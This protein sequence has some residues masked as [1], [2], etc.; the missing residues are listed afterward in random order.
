[1]ISFNLGPNGRSKVTLIRQTEVAECGLAVVAMI[2]R[3]YGKQVSLSSLRRK[4]QTSSR[5]TTMRSLLATAEDMGLSSRAVKLPLESLSMLAVPAVLHWNLNHFVVLEQV[6]GRRA[7]IHNPEGTSRWMQ[8]DEVSNHF[9]GIAA[10]FSPNESFRLTKESEHLRFSQLW[11][12]VSGLRRAIAQTVVLTLVMQAFAIAAPYYMQISLDGVLPAHDLSLLSVLGAGF[13]LFALINSLATGLRAL[14]LLS[15]GSALSYGVSVNVARHLFRLPIDWFERRHVGDILSR[16]Q[17][18]TP[19]RQFLTEGAVAAVLDGFLGIVVLLLMIAYSKLLASVALL[20]FLLYGWIRLISFKALRTSQERVIISA[21]LEQS[22]M[23]ETVRGIATVRLAN[24]ENARHA[25][26]QAKLGDAINAGV[27][28]GKIKTFQSFAS[29]LLLSVENVIS[30][31]IAVSLVIRGG[32]S[33]GMAFAF[34]AYKSQ[35]LQ[36]GAS[37]IDQAVAYRM[38][39]LHLERLADVA[40]SDQDPCFSQS[41]SRIRDFRGKIELRNVSFSYSPSDPLVLDNI[42]LVINPNDHIAITGPSGGGK[43]TLVKI[44]LGLVS[45][46]SGEVIV[47]DVPIEIFGYTAFRQNVGAVLQDDHIFSGTLADNVTLYDENEES[48][49]VFDALTDAALAT[50]VSVMPMGIETLVGD[51]GSSLSGGQKQRLLLA[52]ALYRRPKFLVMDEGTS[53]LDADLERV[54]SARIAELGISRLIVAHRIETIRTASRVLRLLNGK[55]CEVDQAS[56]LNHH[57]D[58]ISD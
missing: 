14:V 31:W 34:M 33:I 40:L 26:W 23:I 54:V 39:S 46:T 11:R 57:Y 49:S 25:F 16:F 37:L 38:L 30:V 53:H 41:Q 32:F 55:L 20:T 15:T 22:S 7:L 24:R 48:G 56:T 13:I 50:D 27:E 42:N 47:D 3:F 43:S 8:F 12:N 21:G 1:M 17:S 6:R 58:L 5:G 28:V 52:R 45:P 2:A 19:I 35:F 18:I 10:E 51:M 36:R 4:H 9:T 44:L 29:T